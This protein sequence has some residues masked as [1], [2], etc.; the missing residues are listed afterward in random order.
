MPEGYTTQ[1]MFAVIQC[2]SANCI[3]YVARTAIT[4][5][6]LGIPGIITMLVGSRKELAN[7]AG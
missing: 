2:S 4:N 7:V 3:I 6:Y 1:L 5:V